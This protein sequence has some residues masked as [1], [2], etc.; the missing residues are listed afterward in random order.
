MPSPLAV[1]GVQKS[2]LLL[3][4]AEGVVRKGKMSRWL[5]AKTCYAAV[6][7][8][9]ATMYDHVPCSSQ[10]SGLQALAEHAPEISWGFLVKP[11]TPTL[12]CLLQ[13]VKNSEV[14]PAP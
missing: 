13:R 11:L 1:H 12:S 4:H 10:A 14:D 3:S 9:L 2:A 7:L 8:F 6:Q 5:I